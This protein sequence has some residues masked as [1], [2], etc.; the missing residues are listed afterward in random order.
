MADEQQP[1]GGDENDKSMN[2]IADEPKRLISR[3]EIKA[4]DDIRWIECPVD[5]WKK[6]AVVWVRTP[7]AADRD[8]LEFDL[9]ADGKKLEKSAIR[10][11]Y[12]ALCVVKGEGS[13]ERLFDAE[14]I[15][16]LRNKNAVPMNRIFGKILEACIVTEDEI[17]ELAKN[18][19]AASG[20]T[21]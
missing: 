18:S 15:V 10:A 2:T 20:V 1:Q 5:E 11:H 14:D 16:W 9:L 12:V 17:D 19:G 13:H 4:S 21:T 8:T 7:T 6:G 3:D